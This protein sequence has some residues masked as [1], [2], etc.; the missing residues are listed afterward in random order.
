MGR[1]HHIGRKSLGMGNVTVQIYEPPPIRHQSPEGADPSTGVLPRDHLHAH[2]TR[3]VPADGASG[4]A[5][6]RADADQVAGVGR[7][8]HLKEARCRTSPFVS[9]G[10]NG[11]FPVRW[12]GEPR[13]HGPNVAHPTEKPNPRLVGG[14][15]GP[16]RGYEDATQPKRSRS[17]ELC[18]TAFSTSLTRSAS[19]LG[20]STAQRSVSMTK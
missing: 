17:Y 12:A 1:T 6:E 16:R 8:W 11:G 7:A 4:D 14:G 5:R 18:P 13:L 2:H 9:P 19:S 15:R 20:F 3:P 10:L